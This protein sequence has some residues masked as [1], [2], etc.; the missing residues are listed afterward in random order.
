MKI[1][2]VSKFLPLT[3]TYGQV[4]IQRL[5]LAE[6][7]RQVDLTLTKLESELIQKCE[8]KKILNMGMSVSQVNLG[9]VN[10]LLI[11]LYA[12]VEDS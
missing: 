3:V 8:G 2:H 9:T 10:G 1:V 5:D 6:F 11:V 12:L 7:I 4:Q